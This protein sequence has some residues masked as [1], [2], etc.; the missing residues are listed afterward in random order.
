[1]DLRS[2]RQHVTA[3]SKQTHC[4]HL[5]HLPATSTV[6]AVNKHIIIISFIIEQGVTDIEELVAG[7][8]GP[9]HVPV[10][11]SCARAA[12]QITA[13]VLETL[14][15]SLQGKRGDHSNITAAK[16]LAPA[17]IFI[18]YSICLVLDRCKKAF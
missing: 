5:P 11:K 17:A 3:R 9:D 8:P 6:A 18:S 4:P 7:Y 10:P 2:N 15:G 12:G 16:V 14:N 13:S 1:M